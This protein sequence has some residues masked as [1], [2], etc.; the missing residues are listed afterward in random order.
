M[1]GVVDIIEASTRIRRGP[2]V[3]SRRSGD[4]TVLLDMDSEHYFGLDAVGSTCWALIDASDDGATFGALLTAVLAEFEV[5]P[6]VAERDLR[7]LVAELLG[8]GLVVTNVV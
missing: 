8:S 4:E 3:L 5:D 7:V 6:A 1:A 2:R